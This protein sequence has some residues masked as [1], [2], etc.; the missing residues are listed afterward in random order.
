MTAT[1][2]TRNIIK[3]F[4]TE[5]ADS[6]DALIRKDDKLFLRFDKIKIT[7]NAEQL[8]YKTELVWH[9]HVNYIMETNCDSQTTQ[10]LYL[11][12]IQG[13]MEIKLL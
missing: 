1:Y 4:P 2:Y 12:G 13:R 3:N 7:Y 11:K 6:D 8:T 9:E 5:D 10:T